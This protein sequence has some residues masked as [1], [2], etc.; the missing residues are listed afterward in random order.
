MESRLQ[1]RVI[2]ETADNIDIDME[3][4]GVSSRILAFM[5][6]IL[7]M[8]LFMLLSMVLAS[9]ILRFNSEAFKTVVPLMLFVIFFS[10]HFLQE[11]LWKGKT[12]GKYLFRIRVMS[13]NGQPI[14][15]WEAVGRNLMRIVDVYLSGIGLVPMLISP[16][17]RRFGDFLVGTVVVNE[18]K[19]KVRPYGTQLQ[20][21]ASQNA[22]VD[23]LQEALSASL[24]LQEL[25]LL[26]DFLARRLELF[27]SSRKGLT[28][29]LEH[30]FLV[31]YPSS[32]KEDFE[33]YLGL[34]SVENVSE[35]KKSPDI[36]KLF[37]R[38]IVG[39]TTLASQAKPSE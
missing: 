19:E 34:R 21:S 8:V 2:I 32:V 36:L 30:Y 23:T 3:L 7:L 6:D 39:V 15:F 20:S 1:S 28:R 17:E 35:S 5:L 14:G 31:R 12:V 33:N 9:L 37:Y 4:A 13:L 25:F 38:K 24:S 18:H 16:T 10:F 11:W 26:R 22:Q 27:I 29:I